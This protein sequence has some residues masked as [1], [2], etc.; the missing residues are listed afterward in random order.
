MDVTKTC[1]KCKQVKPIE[2]FSTTKAVDSKGNPRRNSWCNE[3]RVEYNRAKTGAKKKVKPLILDEHKECL[4]CHDIKHTSE[5][6]PSKRGRLGKSSYCKDCQPRANPEKSRLYTAEYRKRHR[7]RYLASHRLTNYFRRSNIEALSDGT[8]DSEFVKFV[9]SQNLCCWCNDYI[10]YNDRTL[11]HIVELSNGGL[12]SSSNIN[13]ACKS[14]NSKRLNRLNDNNIESL[15]NKF[16]K[17]KTVKISNI[18]VTY[19]DH[20]GSDASV[21]NAARVSFAKAADLFTEEQNSKLITYLAKHNHKSPFNHC[22]MSFRVKAPIFVARQLVK[23]EYLPWNETSRRYV[24]DEPEFFDLDWRHRPE[25]S[26]KQGSGDALSEKDT[27]KADE[28]FWDLAEHSLQAYN[29]LLDLNVAPEQAR[30]ALL[31]DSQTEWVWS[32]SLFAFAKMCNLRLD[33]HTQKEATEVAE[34]ISKKA[35]ELFPVAWQSLVSE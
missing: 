26:V 25:K 20:M 1:S 31:I 19:I 16:N 22:F 21:V 3:C 32:G 33:S 5:F 8:A 28:I 9:Y 17:R 12:H 34:Q 23:H 4:K 11:E 2:K 30:A 7:E 18:E 24:D 35:K 6:Y 27:I 15:E 14:C 29:A 10:E 13:M